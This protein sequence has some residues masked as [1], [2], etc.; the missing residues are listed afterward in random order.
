M[1][2]VVWIFPLLLATS[3]A[4]SA[5][6]PMPFVD[7]E[8]GRI[9]TGDAYLIRLSDGKSDSYGV[10]AP[11]D[12]FTYYLF[13]A[14]IPPKTEVQGLLGKLCKITAKVVIDKQAPGI[15]KRLEVTK[16]ELAEPPSGGVGR[17][18]PQK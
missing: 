3:L 15:G 6:Q 9:E 10:F 16:I 2:K 12:S 13:Q 8:I 14:S 4:V 17:P 11:T 1:K 18:A 5:D 7:T